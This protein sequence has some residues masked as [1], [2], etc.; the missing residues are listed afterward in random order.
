MGLIDDTPPME[1]GIIKIIVVLLCVGL[2]FAPFLPWMWEDNEIFDFNKEWDGLDDDMYA[3]P[4]I[5]YTVWL[6]T[7]FALIFL[8]IGYEIS[9]DIDGDRKRMNELIAAMLFF[10]LFILSASFYYKLND[11]S[12]D[13]ASQSGVDVGVGIGL[14]LVVIAAFLN[15]ILCTVL[16]KQKVD[17][18][19]FASREKP[20]KETTPAVEPTPKPA[21]QPVPEPRPEPVPEPVVEAKPEPAP[22]PQAA[23]PAKAA[24]DEGL[25]KTAAFKKEIEKDDKLPPPPWIK[26][27]ED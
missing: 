6:I 17:E 27:E 22:V 11:I 26:R 14:V 19:F 10:I 1:W 21:P 24:E 9:I 20:V 12:E 3:N 2:F 25:S 18:D 23:P 8:F 5:S 13:W 15:M 7:L 4:S 16:W